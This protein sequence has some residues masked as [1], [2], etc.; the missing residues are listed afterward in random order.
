MVVPSPTSKKQGEGVRGGCWREEAGEG[1][2]NCALRVRAVVESCGHTAQNCYK[3]FDD[4]KTVSCT[5]FV[6]FSP[7]RTRKRFA[8]SVAVEETRNQDGID[9]CGAIGRDS[10]TVKWLGKQIKHRLHVLVVYR[11]LWRG[12]LCPALSFSFFPAPFGLDARS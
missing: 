12:E 5:Y 7:G 8:A 3:R 9:V 4:F 10:V 2:G 11:W 1:R 6:C